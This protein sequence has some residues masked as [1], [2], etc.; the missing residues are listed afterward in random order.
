MNPLGVW[1][2]WQFA[3]ST[4]KVPFFCDTV[5]V[6]ADE[7]EEENNAAAM[8]NMI[9]QVVLNISFEDKPQMRSQQHQL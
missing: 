5:F 1:P 8:L 2:F 3:A 4:P 9:T 6:I 7:E